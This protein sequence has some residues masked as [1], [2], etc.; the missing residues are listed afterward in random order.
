MRDSRGHGRVRDER[1][2]D[3]ARGG[4]AMRKGFAATVIGFSVF[5]M[6]PTTAGAITLTSAGTCTAIN[7]PAALNDIPATAD[8]A[9]VSPAAASTL[10]A[11]VVTPNFGSVKPSTLIS[12]TP[13]PFAHTNGDVLAITKVNGASNEL[14]IGGNFSTITQSNGAQVPAIDF[15]V[16]DATTGNVIYG[17]GVPTNSTTKADKY[18]RSLTSLNGTIYVGGD[19][20]H[21]NGVARSHVVALDSSFAVTSWNPGAGGPVRALATDGSAM[22]IGGEIGQVAAV[23]LSAGTQLWKQ[24]ITGGSVHTL[25][26]TNGVL[27]VG[28]LFEKY[29]TVSQHGLVE[30]NTSNGTVISAFNM[31]LRSDTGVGTHGDYDGEEAISLSVGPNP[32]QIL[33]GVAGHAPPGA[34]SNE[35][36]LVNATTGARSWTYSSI[37]DGQAIGSVGDTTVLGYHNST[38]NTTLAPYYAA[39][40]ENSNGKLTTWDPKITGDTLGNNV[41][42]GNGGVQAM[43]VDQTT[44]TLYMGGAFSQWNGASGPPVAHRVHLRPAAAVHAG[45]PDGWRRDAARQCRWPELDAAD[46]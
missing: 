39:Q 21:W 35:A 25:L 20:D 19:F 30:A 18:V 1:A 5:A 27:Y 22:Y 43:Y 29:G 2:E 11:E 14:A 44:G 41:D 24:D 23:D 46:Q 45:R 17:G 7:G 6:L 8:C 37:G 3:P 42:A 31:H 34:S 36:N 16:L 26:A 33:V 10:Q 28:G 15:A 32:S 9:D 13:I 38:N 40:L 12:S 4:P